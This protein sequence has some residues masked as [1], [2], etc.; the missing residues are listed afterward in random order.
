MVVSNLRAVNNTK[1]VDNRVTKKF[2][3]G[4]LY[5]KKNVFGQKNGVLVG[6]KGKFLA[7]MFP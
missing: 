1:V 3:G 6:R 5:P 4:F 2:C 7:Q